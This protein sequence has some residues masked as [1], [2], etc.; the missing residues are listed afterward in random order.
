[1]C[2]RRTSRRLDTSLDSM[3]IRNLNNSDNAGVLNLN[4]SGA[5]VINSI[6]LNN[7]VGN[8][9]LQKNG[10]GIELTGIRVLEDSRVS[11]DWIEPIQLC[12]FYNEKTII[13]MLEKLNG[14]F[15]DEE[16]YGIRNPNE[17]IKLMIK[18]FMDQYNNTYS[19]A[20]KSLLDDFY[21]F[22][23]GVQCKTYLM[24]FCQSDECTNRDSKCVDRNCNNNIGYLVINNVEKAEAEGRQF[25][26]R[27]DMVSLTNDQTLLRFIPTEAV[28]TE[29]DKL[30][31][32][33]RS[34]DQG[35]QLEIFIS[36][37]SELGKPGSKILWATLKDDIQRLI[38]ESNS[39]NLQDVPKEKL[40]NFIE[41]LG[42]FPSKELPDD[43][44][45]YF[46]YSFD[47]TKSIHPHHPTV[48]DAGE[49]NTHLFEFNRRQADQ[50]NQAMYY[51]TN[52][53]KLSN[54]EREVVHANCR[55]S[56]IRLIDSGEINIV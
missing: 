38:D 54:G 7:N 11:F 21:G 12:S 20:L 9:T 8:F 1:M 46:E 56:D 33:T 10:T 29:V 37:N 2:D 24:T 3:E 4:C 14:Q 48:L 47:M 35:N 41:S 34:V 53:N 43:S 42:L 26:L 15:D 55:I 30:L 31:D 17:D 50:F 36:L 51:D 25:Y 44:W 19:E 22:V 23:E 27:G 13:D 5:S 52:I 28:K 16:R 6:I 49:N 32:K 18:N 40:R 45:T 39:E